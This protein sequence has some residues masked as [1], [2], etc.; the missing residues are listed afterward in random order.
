[1]VRWQRFGTDTLKPV[2]S[3]RVSS[4][5]P[6][7]ASARIL[8]MCH[9]GQPRIGNCIC[10]AGVVKARSPVDLERHAVPPSWPAATDLVSRPDRWNDSSA[11]IYV[12]PRLALARPPFQTNFALGSCVGRDAI[13]S[14]VLT[15][16]YW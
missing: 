10:A 14:V 12:R 1:M 13:A 4:A 15:S 6:P 9:M 2:G 8:E 3:A 11:P 5:L 7:S 16:G